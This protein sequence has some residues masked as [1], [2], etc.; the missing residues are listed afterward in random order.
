MVNVCRFGGVWRQVDPHEGGISMTQLREEGA[1]PEPGR[2]AQDYQPFLLWRGRINV[3]SDEVAGELERDGFGAA[4]GGEP[5]PTFTLYQR[6][7][8]KYPTLGD[9]L[10]TTKDLGAR[11]AALEA[12]GSK[13]GG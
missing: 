10:T 4:L 3:V 7:E 2:R 6:E 8:V 1:D 13:K 12:R 9:V 5:K 11:L